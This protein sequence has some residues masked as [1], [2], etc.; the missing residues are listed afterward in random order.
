MWDSNSRSGH[1]MLAYS[2]RGRAHN[3]GTAREAGSRRSKQRKNWKGLSTVRASTS[4]GSKLFP[5]SNT[6][7]G[8]SALQIHEPMGAF[9]TQTYTVP[10]FLGI[11]KNFTVFPLLFLLLLI[12]C[13]LL[14]VLVKYFYLWFVHAT[15][16]TF[17]PASGGWTTNFGQSLQPL[18]SG[19]A[20]TWGEYNSAW[21]CLGLLINT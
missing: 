7:Q 20:A 21:N 9:L 8:P 17:L 4:K 11:L 2:S 18:S 15:T 3:G 10:L 14:I 12:L 1:V 6:K 16:E 19:L 5:N 13:L